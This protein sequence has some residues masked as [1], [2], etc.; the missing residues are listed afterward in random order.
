MNNIP[1]FVALDFETACYDKL[2]ACS[3]GVAL[4][5]HGTLTESRSW[6]LK[7]ANP[8]RFSFTKIHG[9]T[10]DD[11]KNQGTIKDIWYELEGYLNNKLIIAH[12]AI[13][14]MS[15]L[16]ENLTYYNL[17]YKNYS[18][19]CTLNIARRFFPTLA[20]HKLETLC[21][22][23]KIEYGN[24]D[25]EYDAIS[26]GRLFAAILKDYN[27]PDELFTGTQLGNR[28]YLSKPAFLQCKPADLNGIVS[29]D[30]DATAT[31]DF[32][33]EKCCVITGN[34]DKIGKNRI[35]EKI[36]GYGGKM[37]SS[38]NGKTNLIVVGAEP[39]WSKIEKI[40]SLRESGKDVL[41]LDES[42]VLQVFDKL[43]FLE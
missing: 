20:N 24:H 10:W 25:A 34:F 31:L 40:R 15:V 5:D 16:K 26:C 13:F 33:K 27:Y 2:S 11:V 30:V 8:G 29:D 37:Q 42:E 32:F 9:V 19:S 28:A 1:S 35:I 18:Y 39:G 14:D 7:P 4:F 22:Q 21:K 41:I 23:Y 12:N 6:L 36:Q 3:V 38:V 17:E 43:Y